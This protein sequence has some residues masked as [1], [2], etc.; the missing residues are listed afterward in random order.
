MKPINWSTVR[1]NL[2]FA[3]DFSLFVLGQL[4]PLFVLGAFCFSA[5]YFEGQNH[6]EIWQG[7]LCLFITIVISYFI[8]SSMP[9]QWAKFLDKKHD[10]W[11]AADDKMLDKIDAIMRNTKA[12]IIP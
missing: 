7:P 10:R 1:G 2:Q 4:T 5:I 6:K 8:G 11:L 9:D 3:L 12:D